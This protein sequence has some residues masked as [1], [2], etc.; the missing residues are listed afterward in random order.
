MVLKQAVISEIPALKSICIDAYAKN[1]H[2]H[3]NEG[4]LEWYL[5]REFST[6]RLHSDLADENTA[7]YFIEQDGNAIGFIKTRNHS[8]THLSIENGMEL[9]KIYV[10]P[11]CKGLGI[12]KLALKEIIYIAEQQGKKNL[13]LDVIDTNRSAIAFYQKLGFEQHG[14]TILDVPYFKEE[15]KGMNIMVKVLNDTLTGANS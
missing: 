2:H 11:E 5:D 6:D 4:G 12:G 14:T 13:I 8:S 7:Y 9:E 3:W 1:F 10:L 15:L